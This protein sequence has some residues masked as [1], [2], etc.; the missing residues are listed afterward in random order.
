MYRLFFTVNSSERKYHIK[1][2][3]PSLFTNDKYQGKNAWDFIP[4]D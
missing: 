1:Y 3:D 2:L 4:F